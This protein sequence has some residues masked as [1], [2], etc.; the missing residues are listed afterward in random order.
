MGSRASFVLSVFLGGAV[1]SA[2]ADREIRFLEDRG[3]IAVLE[4]DDSSYDKNAPD[5]ALNSGPR[6]R[7]AR[8]LIETHGDFYDFIVVF[9]NFDFDRGGAVAVY[10]GVRNDVTGIGLPVVDNGEGFGSP[11]RLQGFIDMG[12]VSQYRQDPFSLEP[13][14]PDFRATL[15]VLAHEVGHRFL[16]GPRFLAGGVLRDDLLGKDGA[17]WSF[18]LS[19]EAS[20]LYGNDWESTGGNRYRS[21]GVQSRFS[22]LDLYLMGLLSPEEVSPMTLLVNP[23]VDRTRLPELSAEVEAASVETVSIEQVLAA[24][25]P[26]APGH[27]D[28][29]KDF[30]VA[31]VFLTAPSLLPTESDL[32]AVERVRSNFMDAF[33]SLTR[34]RA[35]ADPDLQHVIAKAA[36]AEPDAFRALGWLLTQQ[37]QGGRF[38]A[39]PT[40]GVR[41]TASAVMALTTMGVRGE[42]VDRARA[43]LALQNP[44]SVDYFARALVAG[45]SLDARRL[46][47]LRNADG[48]YGAAPGYRSDPLDT[49][50]ALQ[51]LAAAGSPDGPAELSELADTLV[52]MQLP[53]GSFSSIAGLPG[54]VMT[55]SRPSR[56][57]NAMAA[58]IFGPMLPGGNSPAAR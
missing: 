42:P 36:G 8:E 6:L 48:G 40:T 41:D 56:S 10:T 14:D 27:R 44:A 5:G 50:L 35:L 51:A 20:F 1:S 43:F 18:L 45:A 3:H 9:T 12:P 38:E 23:D 24:E 58:S 49:S 13:T 26:R 52:S 54:D 21:A 19:S 16:A 25:G 29:Q 37:Q 32:T 28:S 17:H 39:H 7:L 33:F 22:E 53:D 4:H 34:G 31:F 30:T 57:R 55:T 11:K 15:G 46:S 2:G 47:S